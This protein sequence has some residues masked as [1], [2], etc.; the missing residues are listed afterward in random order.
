MAT[1]QQR[2]DDTSSLSSWDCCG[3]APSFSPTLLRGLKPFRGHPGEDPDSHV[4]DFEEDMLSRG[5]GDLRRWPAAFLC[6]LRAEPLVW[7]RRHLDELEQLQVEASWDAVRQAFLERYRPADHPSRRVDHL[8]L[9]LQQG[10]DEPAAAY[11]WRA[12]RL[13]QEVRP[14]PPAVEAAAKA[15]FVSGLRDECYNPAMEMD[16]VDLEACYRRAERAET[17]SQ[18]RRGRASAAAG[19]RAGDGTGGGVVVQVEAAPTAPPAPAKEPFGVTMRALWSEVADL[20]EAAG[21]QKEELARVK[22]A[23]T[24]SEL[25]V[26]RE[27]PALRD[28]VAALSA[29][30]AA[31]REQVVA[32]E[33][34][35]AV[36]QKQLDVQEKQLELQGKQLEEQKEQLAAQEDQLA[37]QELAAQVLRLALQEDQSAAKEK[38]LAELEKQ[39]AKFE[40]QLAGHE[41]QLAV[42]REQ[43]VARGEQMMNQEQELTAQK[44]QLG[45]HAERIAGQDEQLTAH[46]GQL[47]KQKTVLKELEDE[48]VWRVA[49]LERQV[50]AVKSNVA[51]AVGGGWSPSNPAAAGVGGWPGDI[52]S[53]SVATTVADNRAQ[54]PRN[55]SSN[56]EQQKVPLVPGVRRTPYPWHLPPS[57]VRKP[58][59]HTSYAYNNRYG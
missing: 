9:E 56:E 1:A 36:Q 40:Q 26:N 23:V 58:G 31:L 41:Q 20:E 12:R 53:T 3:R 38:Q 13:L 6:S 45:E 22:D 43:V 21:T 42:H 5:V 55:P 19:G 32:Q 14:W 8:L 50:A 57:P 37:E 24:A 4:D 15:C 39:L 29:Q 52:A 35:L 54:V 27:W 44:Q 10:A 46:K 51:A 7:V 34:K 16:G 49:E 18:V 48:W 2:D 33:M 25:V 30:V 17:V 59:Q 47:A 28:E 11:V